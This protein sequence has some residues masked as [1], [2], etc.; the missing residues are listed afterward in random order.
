M[1]RSLVSGVWLCSWQSREGMDADH[2]GRVRWGPPGLLAAVGGGGRVCWWLLPEFQ[3]V[4]SPREAPGIVGN[5]PSPR[6]LGAGSP[7]RQHVR[8]EREHLLSKDVELP[9]SLLEV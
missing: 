3:E 2:P 1:A 7:R 9:A 4:F 8:A 6:D 5:V